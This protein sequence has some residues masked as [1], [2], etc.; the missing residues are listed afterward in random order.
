MLIR[1]DN[2]HFLVHKYRKQIEEHNFQVCYL[3]I[4]SFLLFAN[5]I[6]F[7]SFTWVSLLISMMEHRSL[8]GSLPWGKLW[9][10]FRTVIQLF[11]YY[12]TSWR[13]T[14][15][16][17]RLHRPRW[18]TC[19]RSWWSGL[20]YLRRNRMLYRWTWGKGWNHSSWTRWLRRSQ[21][22]SISDQHR[23]KSL[24]LNQFLVLFMLVQHSSRHQLR[25]WQQ[26]HSVVWWIHQM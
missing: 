20:P 25:A 14:L 8:Q 9:R 26:F 24:L 13:L 6:N 2:R 21:H 5:Q 17:R 1:I 11:Q 19:T 12:P 16:S 18:R 7:E 22:Q 15:C 23:Y 4:W 3:E 10:T